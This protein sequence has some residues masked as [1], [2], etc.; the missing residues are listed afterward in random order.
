MGGRMLG[1]RFS[2]KPDDMLWDRTLSPNDRGQ[3][4]RSGTQ[5]RV[6]QG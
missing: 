4:V 2:P 5:A 1:K 3:G 6:A